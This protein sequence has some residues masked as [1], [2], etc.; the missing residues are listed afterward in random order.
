MNIQQL[1]NRLEREEISGGNA[2]DMRK[3]LR[4]ERLGLIS[5]LRPPTDATAVS[6]RMKEAMRVACMW[7]VDL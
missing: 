2:P 3:V 6:N 5:C 4:D 7:G 1:I